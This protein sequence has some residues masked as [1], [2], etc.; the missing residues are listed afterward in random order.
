MKHKGR[1]KRVET[2]QIANVYKEY[3]FLIV[4]AVISMKSPLKSHS[5]ISLP[6]FP[7]AALTLTT[8]VMISSE[9]FSHSC[10]AV[11][12]KFITWKRFRHASE[13]EMIYYHPPVVW[14]K[15]KSFKWKTLSLFIELSF[16]FRSLSHSLE[17]CM[18]M[19]VVVVGWEKKYTSREK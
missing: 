2:A 7:F 10:F 16:F 4:A 6:H 8:F 5:S 11:E 15:M 12:W 18:M 3:L 19:M 14:H 9:N 17:R 13:Q 1:Q